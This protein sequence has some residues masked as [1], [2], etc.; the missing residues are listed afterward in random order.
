MVDK[1]T[2]A[3]SGI[4]DDPK[5]QTV[6]LENSVGSGL[7]PRNESLV[8]TANQTHS[9]AR[10]DLPLSTRPRFDFRPNLIRVSEGE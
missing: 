7:F 8:T 3:F 10:A 5:F 9:N 2:L 1:L 4:W 6:S